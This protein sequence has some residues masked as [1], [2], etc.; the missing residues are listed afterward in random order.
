MS[1]NGVMSGW[2]PT[3]DQITVATGTAAVLVAASTSNQR[4]SPEGVVVKALAAN[5]AIVYVGG[6]GITVGTGYELSAGNSVNI[7]AADPALIYGITTGTNKV[8][9]MY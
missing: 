5:T 8:C 6:S 1:T 7:P 9:I 2:K 3:T 4:R